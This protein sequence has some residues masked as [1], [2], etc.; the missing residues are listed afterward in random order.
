MYNVR[1]IKNL[2]NGTRM[3]KCVLVSITIKVM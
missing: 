3:G 1:V 2:K